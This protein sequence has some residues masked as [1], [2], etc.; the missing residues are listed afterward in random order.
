M[1][2]SRDLSSELWQELRKTV[3]SFAAVASQPKYMKLF[4]LII[5]MNA[6]MIFGDLVARA[7]QLREVKLISRETASH[8]LLSTDGGVPEWFGYFEMG[9]TSLFLVV[10]AVRGRTITLALWSVVVC[11]LMLDDAFQVHEH[12]GG[13]LG[14][15]LSLFS[16]PPEYLQSRGELLFAAITG[17]AILTVLTIALMRANVGEAALAATLLVPFAALAF[18][19]A[20]VDFLHELVGGSSNKVASIMA[21]LEDGGELISMGFFLIF[22]IAVQA[23]VRQTVGQPSAAVA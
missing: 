22:A 11:Y 12:M 5:A 4:C 13:L 20:G 3:A 6:L 21:I 2:I 8:F 14:S 19:A 17:I 18:F 10:A 16:G 1:R 15:D 9:V 23:L 7:L